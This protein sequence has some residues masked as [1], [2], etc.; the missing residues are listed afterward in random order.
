M[1]CTGLCLTLMHLIVNPENMYAFNIGL[2]GLL[3][4]SFDIERLLCIPEKEKSNPF[5]LLSVIS[6][7]PF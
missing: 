2:V 5:R 6:H 3:L 7:P 4:V 1:Q